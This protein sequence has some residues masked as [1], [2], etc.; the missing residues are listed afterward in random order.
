MELSDPQL[1]L[2]DAN[3]N[4]YRTAGNIVNRVLNSLINI[5]KPGVSVMDLCI[6]GD[7]LM[8]SE[9]DKIYTNISDKG[10][11]F[12]TCINVNDIGAYFTTKHDDTII[13]NNNDLVKIELGVH[14]DGF[15]A[16]QVYT[17]LVSDGSNVPGLS[18]KKGQVTLACAQASRE[19]LKLMKPGNK[20]TDV[21]RVLE[22]VAKKYN[23]SL[24]VVND[25]DV[26][27]TTSYQVSRYI[28]DGYNDDDEFIHQLILC[29]DNEEVYGY[30]LLEEEFLEDDVYAIDVTICSGNGKLNRL[31]NFVN[32][33]RRDHR[34]RN[35][36]KLKSSR[37]TINKFNKKYF[38]VNIDT[39]LDN[40]FR[41]GLKECINK[42]L[43]IP[44]IP[45]KEKDGEVIGRVKFTVI[46]KKNP[47]LITGRSMNEQ[48]NKF[49][50]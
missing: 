30:K 27:P 11:C 47:I 5:I 38:P 24:P 36:L 7:E 22:R 21:V 42:D 29:R 25:A 43:L 48:I 10:V 19:I 1:Q 46:V 39:Y 33:Y 31:N 12:P 15:P 41:L 50:K 6:K 49:A 9:L 13:I 8:E 23:C 17:L 16:L 34:N 3:I 44:Y 26:A 20:N 45:V 14:I 40:R 4:K 37:Q 2:N 18:S 32:L 35:N 28:I